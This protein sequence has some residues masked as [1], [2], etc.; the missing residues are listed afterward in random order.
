MIDYKKKYLKYK[1][2]YLQIKKIY[3]GGKKEKKEKTQNPLYRRQP[4]RVP[5]GRSAYVG[6]RAS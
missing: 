6:R 3:G 5:S 4:R 2:K 1:K